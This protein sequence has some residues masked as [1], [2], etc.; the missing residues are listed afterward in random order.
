MI[1]TTTADY[2]A[3]T[4]ISSIAYST[5]VTISAIDT[6]TVIIPIFSLMNGCYGLIYYTPNCLITRMY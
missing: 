5:L 4:I 1:T 2:I 6:S 3:L